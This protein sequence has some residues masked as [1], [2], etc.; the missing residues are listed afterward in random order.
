M[1]DV[2]IAPARDPVLLAK[3]AATLDQ[4]SGG[5]FTLG[6]SVGSRP[7]DFSTTGFNLKDRGKRFDAG[8]DLMHRAWRGEA[9]P[10]TQRPVAPRPVNGHSVPV[11][12]GGRTE[13]SIERAV[14]YGVGYTLGGG[15]PENL[16]AMMDRVTAAWNEAG[17]NG[18]PRFAALGYF[19]LGDEVHAEAE[20]NV[21]EYY[22]DYGAS[23]WQNAIKTPDEARWRKEMFEA[24]GCDE[25]IMFMTAPALGQAERLAAAVLT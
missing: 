14:K 19:A 13:H 21:R 11:M 10:G 22:G 1:T 12:I 16:K 25:Y 2:L 6:I 18:K 8:L 5:R 4:V 17:R 3:Q 9:V 23:V 15:S 20:H 7:D 24:V